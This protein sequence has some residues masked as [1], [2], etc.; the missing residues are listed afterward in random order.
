[1]FNCVQLSFLHQSTRSS[2]YPSSFGL[3]LPSVLPPKSVL[4]YTIQIV[5]DVEVTIEN[6]FPI[7]G[8]MPRGRRTRGIFPTTGKKFS[9]VT[10]NVSNY[11]F[12]YTSNNT[13]LPGGGGLAWSA[14][15]NDADLL[16]CLDLITEA[17]FTVT[18]TGNFTASCLTDEPAAAAG[19][20][21]LTTDCT[22]LDDWRRPE[23]HH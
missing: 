11:F 7:V 22:G 18:D 8:N 3:L 15:N 21:R 1:M 13:V 17:S 4:Y 5:T 2:V 19:A 9:I 16:S 12:C 23:H 20:L 6:S 14:N 10:D